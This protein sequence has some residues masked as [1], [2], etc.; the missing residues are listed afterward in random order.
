MDHRVE[1]DGKVVSEKE[2][3]TMY[4]RGRSPNGTL[5]CKKIQDA[6]KNTRP[7]IHP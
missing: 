3:L 6:N 2:A 5:N 7:A 1:P 4:Q